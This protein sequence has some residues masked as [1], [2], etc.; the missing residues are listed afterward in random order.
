MGRKYINIIGEKFGELTVVSKTSDKDSDGSFFWK[1]S[2]SCGGESYQSTGQLRQKPPNNPK[3]C[4]Q[5]KNKRLIS[6]K[7]NFNVVYH[8][9][10]VRHKKYTNNSFFSKEKF[11]E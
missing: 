4:K 2:C 8:K 11:E 9:Y 3:Y 5:C 6:N 1:L 7:S 10:K